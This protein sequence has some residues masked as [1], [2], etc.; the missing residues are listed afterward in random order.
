MNKSLVKRTAV[1]VF[2]ILAVLYGVF[3]FLNQPRGTGKEQRDNRIKA[4]LSGLFIE[5]KLY[6]ES[7]KPFADFCEEKGKSY[8]SAIDYISRLECHDSEDAWAAGA[9]LPYQGAYYCVD[10]NEA[11]GTT[12]RGLKEGETECPPAQQ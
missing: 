5:G 11:Q 8:A 3:L 4:N 6:A 7:S 10:S 2:V 9:I 12:V 1:L